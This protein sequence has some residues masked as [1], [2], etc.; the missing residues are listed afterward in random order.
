MSD[1][2]ICIVTT[3]LE[4][5]EHYEGQILHIGSEED[6]KS[7]VDALPGVICNKDPGPISASVISFKMSAEYKDLKIGMN[8]KEMKDDIDD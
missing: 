5:E 6:C 4:F 7:V 2:P 8:W 3:M 1:S